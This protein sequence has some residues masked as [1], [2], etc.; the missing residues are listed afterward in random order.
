MGFFSSF[1]GYGGGYGGTDSGQSFS[2]P[3]APDAPSVDTPST[4]GIDFVGALGAAPADVQTGLGIA[5]AEGY[6]GV[7]SG[8]QLSIP[9]Y[10]PEQAALAKAMATAFGKTTTE[11]QQTSI[12]NAVLAQQY[13]QMEQPRGVRPTFTDKAKDVLSDYFLVKD[14][15]G[16]L[17]PFQTGLGLVGKATGPMG[18]LASGVGR[19]FLDM[20]TFDR[21]PAIEAELQAEAEASG[22]PPISDKDMP[23]AM[24]GY[25][26][27]EHAE[28]Q[29]RGEADL[30]PS[31][32][33]R[34]LSQGQ[35]DPAAL[36]ASAL[37]GPTHIYGALPGQ[38]QR[39]G[40]Y[41]YIP[42]TFGPRS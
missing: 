13:N 1:A 7:D 4:D 32:P 33:Q 24:K 27:A 36:P 31:I 3:S 41:Q 42:Q 19:A 26:T 23:A 40:A 20:A 15:E 5:A 6:S 38:R 30:S 8:N 39:R 25:Y 34:L 37:F 29:A 14:A 18:M 10:S 28:N 17:M 12:N 21:G 35:Q 11:G 16:N 22:L 9:Q 2:V